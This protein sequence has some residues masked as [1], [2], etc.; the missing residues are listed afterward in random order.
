MKLTWLYTRST[1]FTLSFYLWT[2]GACLAFLP[3]LLLP[4]KQALWI[5]R[6][7]VG[8]IYL[9]EK[10]VL[11]LDYEVRGWEHVPKSGAF[12]VAAK[13]KSPYETMKLNRLF[14]DP[15]IILKKEL[16]H[17]PLWGPFLAKAEPIAIDRK[18]GTKAVLQLVDGAMRIKEQNRPIVIF[19]QGTRVNPDT[20]TAERPY[21]IGVARMALAT[22]MPVIPLALNSGV[23]WPKGAFLKKPGRVVFEF[24][25]ALSPTTD[26]KVLLTDLE[27][28]L[29][30]ASR[31]LAEIN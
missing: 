20:T 15:A 10:Y 7:W 26:E 17:V 21:K 19:P 25:P 30:A 1:V 28:R 4:K 2:L 31:R 3:G 24:L 22:G 23:F 13:H 18:S 5:V 8:G 6:C 29:E 27:T 16:L 11:G 12:I 9:L 14:A